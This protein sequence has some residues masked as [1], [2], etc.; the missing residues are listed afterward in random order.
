MEQNEMGGSAGSAVVIA[1]EGPQFGAAI[2]G[3]TYAERPGVYALVMQD[4]QVLVIE[5]P[6]G[7]FLPG[8]GID[9]GE[10]EA[11]ALRRELLEEAGV[12]IVDA[13]PFASARQYVIERETGLGFNKVES[14]YTVRIQETGT[15]RREL[16]HRPRWVSVAAALAGLREEAQR[17]AVRLLTAAPDTQ[18]RRHT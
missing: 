5:T 11:L 17:W 10:D 13:T 18:S 12:T 15:E 6:A 16:D 9:G 14:F 1:H 2:P 7:F 3:M 4:G 8:G